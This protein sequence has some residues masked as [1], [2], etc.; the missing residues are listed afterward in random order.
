M[1][2]ILYYACGGGKIERIEW[3]WS[4]AGC[5]ATAQSEPEDGRL[6]NLLKVNLALATLALELH[7][8]CVP[9]WLLSLSLRS[10]PRLKGSNTL[11]QKLIAS[12]FVYIQYKHSPY[13]SFQNVNS[14]IFIRL[15]SLVFH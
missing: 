14:F 7:Q 13:Y 3:S 2:A 6:N 12:N 15:A 8:V 10:R 5:E 1:K 9:C 11:Q 4:A